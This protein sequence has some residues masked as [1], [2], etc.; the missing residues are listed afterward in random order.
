MPKNLKKPR[1][2]RMRHHWDKQTWSESGVDNTRRSKENYGQ[3]CSEP[4]YADLYDEIANAPK[5]T[6]DVASFI[7]QPKE[8]GHYQYFFVKGPLEGTLNIGEWRTYQDDLSLRC[9]DMDIKDSWRKMVHEQ[10]RSVMILSAVMFVF[11]VAGLISAIF[12]TVIGL[13]GTGLAFII[14]PL[15]TFALV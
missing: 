14:G 9:P 10:N 4:N 2:H 5:P 12:S 8:K 15:G 7:L 11:L 3:G 6:Q 1:K 13:I